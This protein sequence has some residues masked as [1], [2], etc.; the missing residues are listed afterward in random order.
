MTADTGMVAIC[1]GELV[2]KVGA[3]FIYIYIK[4]K[5]ITS[6]VL[7]HLYTHSCTYMRSHARLTHIHIDAHMHMHSTFTIIKHFP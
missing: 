5:T 3:D 6:N 2:E 1:P 4:G 7:Q